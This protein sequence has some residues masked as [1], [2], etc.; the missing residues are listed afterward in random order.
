M[1]A[2]FPA[3]C[4]TANVWPA[5][6]IVPLRA[7]PTLAAT[8]KPTDPLPSPLVPDVMAIHVALLFAVHEHPVGAVTPTDPVPP[9][10]PML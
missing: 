1:H 6:E 10:A 9:A 2:G 5:I 7:G 8:L 3:A 4:A